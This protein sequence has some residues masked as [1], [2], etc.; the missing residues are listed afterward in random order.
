MINARR[1]RPERTELNPVF[2]ELKESEINDLMTRLQGA[3]SPQSFR[4]LHVCTFNCEV[5]DSG[6][7]N[8]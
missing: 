6:G 5:S 1:I 7:K 8:E 3:L 4:L 2:P